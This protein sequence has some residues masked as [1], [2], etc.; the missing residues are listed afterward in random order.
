MISGDMPVLELK[1]PI[2][3]EDTRGTKVLAQA[4][5]AEEQ[6]AIH[7]CPSPW[8]GKEGIRSL[9]SAPL[10][11]VVYLEQ[12]TENRMEVFEPEKAVIPLMSQFMVL[13]DTEEEIRA[14][15]RLLD[16]MLCAYPVWK[17]TNRGNPESTELLRKTLLEYADLQR[18]VV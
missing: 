2:K 3:A 5:D 16:T 11:G 17:L 4:A 12:G 15:F 14:L 13:P 1:G 9:L 6:A 8:N 18:G 7:V 10:G